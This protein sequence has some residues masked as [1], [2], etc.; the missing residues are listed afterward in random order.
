FSTIHGKEKLR[1]LACARLYQS[2]STL[3]KHLKE[4]HR[5]HRS[6]HVCSVCFKEFRVEA[7]LKQHMHVHSTYKPYVCYYCQKAYTQYS[8]LCRHN[9][10]QPQCNRRKSYLHKINRDTDF[11]PE[12][13]MLEPQVNFFESSMVHCPAVPKYRRFQGSLPI[14]T[15]P[16]IDHSME[17]LDLSLPKASNFISGSQKGLT[18]SSYNEPEIDSETVIPTVAS[19]ASHSLLSGSSP[20][21]GAYSSLIHPW[22]LSIFASV[23][24]S[25]IGAL[26]SSSTERSS[27]FSFELLRRIA[28]RT[29]ID[30]VNSAVSTLLPCS[31]KIPYYEPTDNEDPV[32]EYRRKPGDHSPIV[33]GDIESGVCESRSNPLTALVMVGLG[34]LH[35]RTNYQIP[36]LTT[37]NPRSLPVAQNSCINLIAHWCMAKDPNRT[38]FN[39]TFRLERPLSA[40]LG[41]SFVMA[42]NS[43][44]KKNPKAEQTCV[45]SDSNATNF[46]ETSTK[47][48]KFCRPYD[49]P[50]LLSTPSSPQLPTSP[51][52]LKPMKAES[53]SPSTQSL[54]SPQ[55]FQSQLSVSNLVHIPEDLHTRKSRLNINHTSNRYQCSFCIKS[56]PRSANLN[57]HLRT[58]TGEQPYRCAYCPR[59]FSISSNM[60]RHIRNIHQCQR[61]FACNKCSRAFAQRTNLYR[62][63]RN[64]KD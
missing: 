43:A 13:V 45:Q 4:Y 58:H 6:A 7:G 27:N 5:P 10:L 50:R 55:F 42:E 51:V 59:R 1:C 18:I 56:F 15:E 12:T 53:S 3:N 25:E 60:Q 26:I 8:N 34:L 9:R 16:I 52:T 31:N 35:D 21:L 49:V 17:A 11:G 19:S 41:Q 37:D 14:A 44:T 39:P 57:R 62:H 23:D 30:S 33:F 64:H 29:N 46:S 22:L 32:P 20:A 40:K 24:T 54:T 36:W 47:C 61:P 48:K 28:S 2:L 63:M 38:W